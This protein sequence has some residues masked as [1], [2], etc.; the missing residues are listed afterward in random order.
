MCIRDS[1][2]AEKWKK[3]FKMSGVS[4]DFYAF[5]ERELDET[6]PWEHISSGVSREFFLR[7]REKAYGETTTAD[8]R[9]GCAGCG[10]NKRVKCEMEGIYG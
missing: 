8:C 2:K 7:E 10:I 6:L 4:P 1:F 5:R 9:H 3:A